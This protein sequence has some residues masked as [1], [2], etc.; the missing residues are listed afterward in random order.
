MVMPRFEKSDNKTN[1][2][3]GAS[4]GSACDKSGAGFDWFGANFV[5]PLVNTLCVEPANAIT[6]TVERA[7]RQ[8]SLHR[9]EPLSV[10]DT[11][12]K[13]FSS[14]MVSQSVACAVGSVGP[15][16][17]A[18]MLAGNTMRCAGAALKTEGAIATFAQNEKV[19]QIVGAGVYDGMKETRQGESHLR[20]GIAG[21]A[22]FAVLEYS[23]VDPR[24]SLIGRSLDRFTSGFVGSLTHV[25]ISRPDVFSVKSPSDINISSSVLTGGFINVLLPGTQQG[26]R[27]LQEKAS[28]RMG[29]GIPIDRYLESSSSYANAEAIGAGAA[30]TAATTNKLFEQNRWARIEPNSKF[31]CYLPKRD[32]VS[33][34]TGSSRETILHELHHRTEALAGIAE[35]GFV[36]AAAY[37]NKDVN[38]AWQ[39]YAQ[40]RRAQEIRAEIASRQ[41]A[42]SSGLT[43]K[44]ELVDELKKT[45]PMARSAGGDSYIHLWRR[46]FQEFLRTSGKFRP[47]ADYSQCRFNK[48]IRDE[49]NKLYVRLAGRQPKAGN[50]IDDVIERHSLND[51][52]V[53]S[54]FKHV[55]EFLKPKY[56]NVVQLPLPFLAMQTLRLVARPEK[57]K[58]GFHP[59]C[60]P[61]ALEYATYVKHPENA[62]S[63]ISQ[64]ALSGKYKS[65]DGTS[66]I[67][68][69][70]NVI[71]ERTKTRSFANQLFQ[72]TSVNVHWQ[73]KTSLEPWLYAGDGID[74]SIMAGAIRYER[75]PHNPFIP[76]L[77]RLMDYSK[78]PVEP[79]QDRLAP[80]LRNDLADPLM[81]CDS[82]NDINGQ[83]NG[84]AHG[85]IALPW[86]L[87]SQQVLERTL[88]ERHLTD[89]LPV[90]TVIDCRHPLFR[91]GMEEPLPDV[92]WHI[93]AVRGYDPATKTAS[94]FN[95]W[96]HILNGVSTRD[97]YKA[98]KEFKISSENKS[99]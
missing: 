54:V 49:A 98:N 92:G 23:H 2:A 94:I 91:H 51:E 88:R 60:G 18:G 17:L 27:M 45:I 31:D 90:L 29:R 38:R 47:E 9:I 22:N 62:A 33:L 53:L 78:K 58:Q 99:L 20:N 37:L 66:I 10:P 16:A 13:P 96:G 32:M 95:P 40:V 97:L 77:Y 59:T 41:E 86:D 74:N 76:D 24:A 73:R 11:S 79:L 71:P 84:S 14:E 57:V 93:V 75:Q 3:V 68:D 35:P 89:R 83:I 55:N 8:S 4:D 85:D 21:A 67:L 19:A 80:E 46:E 12:G 39:T 30:F 7:A 69:L 36:Q 15:Y 61:A 42:N 52:Q 28:L 87:N 44:A 50:A 43:N 5:N 26:L 48:E 34:S 63:L 70:L 65:A 81:D 56:N 1:D 25:A 72:T 82:L 6:Q 64:V